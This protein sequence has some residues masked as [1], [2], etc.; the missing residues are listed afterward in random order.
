MKTIGLIGGISWESTVTYYEII[1]TEIAKSLGGFHS[2]KILMFNVDFA[3]LEENMKNGYWEGN[4]VI[5]ADAASRLEKAG[6]D[7]IVIATNTMHKLVPEIEKIIRIP[8]LHIADVAA[9]AVKKDGISKV[10][11]LGTKFTLT[12][13]F[14]TKRLKNAGLEVVLPDGKD[15]ELVNDVIFNE[16][17]LGK[18]LDT[19]RDE[20]K[21]II[22]KMKEA[23]AEAVILGCTEIGMLIKEE[24]SPI[25]TYDTTILHAQ[26]AAKEAL[27]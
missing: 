5:L 23:G 9:G 26:A 6:A 15:I 24:D 7:Y 18:V 8:I 22:G 12:Q 11:L 14:V 4:A 19:S 10:G 1:N 2:A 16:L 21:R 13:D 27:N 20:Y 25:P 17:C 3:E